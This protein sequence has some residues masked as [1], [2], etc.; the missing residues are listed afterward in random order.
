MNDRDLLWFNP[1]NL[2]QEWGDPGGSPTHPLSSVL[3][4][5]KQT[6][7]A[8]VHLSLSLFLSFSPFLPFLEELTDTKG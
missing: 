5:S 4:L 7:D 6:T 8:K 2:M 3:E 1:A